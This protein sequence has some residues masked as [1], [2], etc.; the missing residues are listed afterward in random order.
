MVTACT[1]EPKVAWFFQQQVSMMIDGINQLPAQTYFYQQD[2]I[3]DLP[4][5]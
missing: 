3:G 2:I 4:T 5:G 1:I